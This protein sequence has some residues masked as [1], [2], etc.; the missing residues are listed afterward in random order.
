VRPQVC[1][2]SYQS[3]SCFLLVYSDAKRQLQKRLQD[4]EVSLSTSSAALSGKHLSV[5]E[6]MP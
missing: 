1:S 3:F 2:P 4:D 6:T 5:P